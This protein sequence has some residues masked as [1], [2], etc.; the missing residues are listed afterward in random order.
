MVVIMDIMVALWIGDGG[1]GMDMGWMM[2]GMDGV[3]GMQW[4]VY[5]RSEYEQIYDSC[6]VLCGDVR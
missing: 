4:T 6:G 2:D 1:G 3:G 5:V